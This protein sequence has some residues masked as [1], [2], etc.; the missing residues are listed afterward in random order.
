M[1]EI[2]DNVNTE[3]TQ[4]EKF[5]KILKNIQEELT[6]KKEV[7][8]KEV[9]TLSGK[10]NCELKHTIELSA[11]AIAQRQMIIEERTNMYYRLY[12][13]L[14]KLKQT[15]KKYF[16]YYSTKY[17][18][19]TNSGEKTKLIEADIRYYD[20][21]IDYVQTYI[22]FLSETLKSID[23]IIYSVKNKIDLYNASG[24]E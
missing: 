15:K 6:K 24:L 22:D 20:A 1:A 8:N 9:K 7:W 13:D 10:L 2:E 5:E 11:M 12:T 21:K 17:P 14:P 23:H 3:Q 19:K 4:D 16:E 18:I